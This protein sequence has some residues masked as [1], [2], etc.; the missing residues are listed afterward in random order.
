MSMLMGREAP[1]VLRMEMPRVWRLVSHAYPELPFQQTL[2][3]AGIHNVC[4]IPQINRVLVLLTYSRFSRLV[5]QAASG[6]Q[7]W[8]RLL[9]V[10]R[11][12]SSIHRIFAV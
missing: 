10:D 6:F 8:S 2:R 1:D 9:D 11:E 12:D 7:A 4:A 3:H 5:F